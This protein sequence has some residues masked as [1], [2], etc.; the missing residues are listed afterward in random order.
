MSMR[1]RARAAG[2]L[3][4]GLLALL[5]SAA[6]AQE[7]PAAASDEVAPKWTVPLPNTTCSWS[8]SEH[9]CHPSSPGVGDLN[10][11]GRLDIVVATNNGHVVAVSNG[12]VLWDRD[13]AGLFG[14]AANT[15]SF[16]SS[17]A[18]ADLDRDGA[19]EVVVA[20]SMNGTTCQPGGVIVLDSRGQPR[21]NWPQLS[22]DDAGPI[23][24]CPAPFISTPAL[25]D[26]DGD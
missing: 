2:L 13:V 5:V 25:G 11:D 18:I 3:L 10:G 17:P 1:L 19:L 22:D 16:A 26:L 15:Q 4:P 20:T 24:H 7:A 6:G 8:A 23:A 12:A 14:M 9:N 21:P